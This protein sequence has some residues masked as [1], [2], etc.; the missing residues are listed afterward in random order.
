MMK[1]VKPIKYHGGKEYLAKWICSLMP[2]HL[3]YVEP[4]FGGGSVLLEKNPQGV[5]EVVN[6]IDGHLMNFWTVLATEGLFLDFQRKCEATPFS[7]PS[8]SR[9]FAT[10]AAGHRADGVHYPCV[11]C[12]VAFFIFCRQSRAGQMRDF[13]TLS[14]NRTR[15]GMN[16]QVSAWL[17]A[18]ESLPA[19]HARLKRV[20]ILCDDALRVVRQQDGPNTLFY[21]DPPYLGTVRVTE[22][23]F[24]HEMTR[25][26]HVELLETLSCIRGKFLL[27][28]YN[29][30]LYDDFAKRF[31]W[32]RAEMVIDCKASASAHKP[33]RTECVWM[34]Y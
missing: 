22:D 13:A 27:S 32:R 23:V 8:W 3:H 21:L 17:N 34:N 24:R 10:I 16:E 6:D 20:L 5:S 7:S 29:T 30:N 4:Y 26:Q 18:I 11:Q 14:R 19:V 15:R 12:A 33:Q 1:L 2:H 28:G 25:E 31:G 9:A